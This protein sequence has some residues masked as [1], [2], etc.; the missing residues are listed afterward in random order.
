MRALLGYLYLSG[1]SAS[2]D[3]RTDSKKDKC[4]KEIGLRA[5]CLSPATSH[6]SPPL[7]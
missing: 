3:R 5:L 2:V 1:V 6:D 7:T 4:L